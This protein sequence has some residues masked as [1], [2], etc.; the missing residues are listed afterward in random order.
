MSSWTILDQ[1]AVPVR[2][3]SQENQDCVSSS[4][5]VCAACR[6]DPFSYEAFREAV[7]DSYCYTT[8]WAQIFQSIENESCSWCRIIGRTR[9]GM[10]GER[11]PHVDGEIVDVKF[12]I[13]NFEDGKERNGRITIYLNGSKEAIYCIHPNDDIVQEVRY[14]DY[15][16]VLERLKQCSNH[17][18]CPPIRETFLPT[19]II[20]CSNPSKP[21]LV[22]THRQIT[23]HYC[24][25]SYVWGGEQKQKTTKSN[26]STYIHEGINVALPQTIADAVLVTAKLGIRYLWVDALCI[27]QDSSEDKD[28]ELGIMAHI[29]RDAYLTICASSAFRADHGFLPNERAPDV[30]PF[31]YAD[32]LKPP[33][34]MV[35]KYDIPRPQRGVTNNL[36]ILNSPLDDRAWCLQESRLSPRKLT[37]RPPYA[38]YKCPSFY[39]LDISLPP[40]F[41]SHNP[42][43]D[44]DHFLFDTNKDRGTDVA[45]TDEF[46]GDLLDR[47]QMLLLDYSQRKMTV[48]SDKFVAL[49][50]IAETYQA[51]L[52]DQYVAGLWKRN[53]LRDLLW[54]VRPPQGPDD[55]HLPRPVVYRAP[56]WSWAAV[57][58]RLTRSPQPPALGGCYEAEIVACEVT[59]KISSYPFG[60]ITSGKLTLRAKIYPLMRDGSKCVFGEHRGT[61]ADNALGRGPTAW[62]WTFPSGNCLEPKTGAESK[63]EV[64]ATLFDSLEGTEQDC[65]REFFIVILWAAKNWQGLRDWMQGLLVLRDADGE[66]ER[67]RR[68]GKLDLWFN[69]REPGWLE[70]MHEYD[71]QWPE[72]FDDLPSTTITLI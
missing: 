59:P 27:I 24:A 8:T 5:L 72:W 29:Y 13:S 35:A 60:E 2:K 23:G 56:T 67:Y 50:S 41:R 48:P 47:W 4:P 32:K 70:G 68:V 53:L 49:G 36:V 31:Y 17:R 39:G 63:Q 12:Q 34:R 58:G 61:N 44:K 66:G 71:I 57:D 11:F 42:A 51:I 10:P 20:D 43:A 15:A 37:F 7:T 25:L 6:A 69:V 3:S 55:S 1:L 52:D 22:E 45:S 28:S 18:H 19:R 30:L 21:R 65:P 14:V 54:A 33:A 16:K 40:R 62:H 9:D 38:L 26:I 46:R 64:A